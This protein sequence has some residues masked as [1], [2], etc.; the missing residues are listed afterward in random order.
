MNDMSHGQQ[1]EQSHQQTHMLSTKQIEGLEI[2]TMGAV[3]LNSFLTEEQLSNPI[4]ELESSM[5]PIDS[6]SASSG[7]TDGRNGLRSGTVGYYALC[8]YLL[9]FPSG[10]CMGPNPHDRLL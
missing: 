8:V 7:Q 10:P 4:L 9:C 6:A 1:L 2:L 3:E 5:Q